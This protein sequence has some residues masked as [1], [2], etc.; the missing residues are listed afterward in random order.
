ALG[1]DMAM[2][3]R[4]RELAIQELSGGR[5]LRR[6][7]VH[8]I[9]EKAGLLTVKLRGY[10]L[11]WHLAQTGT[12]CFGPTDRGEQSV[13]LLDEWVKQP[14]QLQRDEPLGEGA[15]RYFRSHEPAT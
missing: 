7:A 15:L 10:H 3:E 11:L 13:V 1:L 2:I 12:L 4:A 6:D 14:R 8:A 5:Q 9:W